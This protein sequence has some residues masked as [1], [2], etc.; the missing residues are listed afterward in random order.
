MKFEGMTLRQHKFFNWPDIL[1]LVTMVQNQ[2]LSFDSA[3]T[4][5]Q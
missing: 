3:Q 5:A 4:L 2:P 1:C